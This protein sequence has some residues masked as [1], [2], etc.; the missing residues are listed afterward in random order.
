MRTGLYAGTFDPLTNG[1]LDILLRSLMVFDDIIIG[2]A[3]TTPKNTFFSVDERL[4]M[5]NAATDG[6]EHVRV[7]PFTGLLMDFAAQQGVVAVVR[8]LRVVSDF[9]YEFQM[10]LMNRRLNNDIE[11]VFLMPSEEHT[12]LSSSLVRE[13]ASAGGDVSQFVPELVATKLARKFGT[14]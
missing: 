2:V 7:K 5:L 13:I 10:A 9:E 11:T 8:G 12:Y 6:I 3:N 4:E 14:A 1:H